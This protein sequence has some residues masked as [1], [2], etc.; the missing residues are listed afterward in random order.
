MKKN[1]YFI[2]FN[3]GNAHGDIRCYLRSLGYH[4]G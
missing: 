1:N 4:N 3:C 2:D